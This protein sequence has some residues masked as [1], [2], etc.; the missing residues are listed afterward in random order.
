MIIRR[1]LPD[2][3]ESRIVI[4]QSARWQTR[5]SVWSPPTDVYETGEDFFIRVEIA[6]MRDEDFEI[7]LNNNVLYVSGD[8]PGFVGRRAYHQME[9]LSGRFEVEASIGAPVNESACE[10]D[11]ADGFLTIKLPKVKTDEIR[12]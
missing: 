5:S 11:Y 3:F 7:T 10:A 4:L 6:G 8:R 2:V 1:S 9:I 12:E